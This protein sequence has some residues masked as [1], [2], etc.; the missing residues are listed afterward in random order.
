MRFIGKVK[1]GKIIF[2][3]EA[4]L[5]RYLNGIKGNVWI[6]IESSPKV[7]SNKQN[8][9]Y[10]LILRQLSKETGYDLDEMHDIVK[11]KF[12]VR[13]TTE[14]KKEEFTEFL[15]L[16]IRFAAGLG[17]IIKDPRQTN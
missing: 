5:R 12:G 3:N 7:R 6:D 17:I 14:L 11:T 9:Y 10:R 2:D 16:I 15:D 8:R 1:N 4:S 13:S